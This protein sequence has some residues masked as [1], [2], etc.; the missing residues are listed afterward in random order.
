MTNK[1]KCNFKQTLCG[2]LVAVSMLASCAKRQDV[3]DVK[4]Q[5]STH[6]PV[7][8]VLTIELDDPKQKNTSLWYLEEQAKIPFS[9][10]LT[11]VD[12]SKG[13]DISFE[14]VVSSGKGRVLERGKNFDL[15]YKDK[16]L[17]PETYHTASPKVESGE[18]VVPLVLTV[19][20]K[21]FKEDYN[22]EYTINITVQLEGKTL[23]ES[24]SFNIRSFKIREEVEHFKGVIDQIKNNGLQAV[25]LTASTLGILSGIYKEFRKVPSNFR[26]DTFNI[27][28]NK[29]LGELRGLVSSIAQRQGL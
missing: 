21:A 7:D 9:F 8:P 10:T 1:L 23:S 16:G 20:E 13:K 22:D 3:A 2:T 12:S 14:Y 18:V 29:T 26:R 25:V 6:K 5:K 19:M 24:Y 27:V 4:P 28:S 17:E 15:T 11:G